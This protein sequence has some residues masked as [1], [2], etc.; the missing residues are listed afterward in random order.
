[1]GVLFRLSWKHKEITLYIQRITIF[2]WRIFE[3]CFFCF[4]WLPYIL[5]V[6]LCVTN[7]SFICSWAKIIPI[8]KRPERQEPCVGSEAEAKHI[9]HL[10]GSWKKITPATDVSAPL[11]TWVGQPSSSRAPG[12][13]LQP[14]EAG[15]RFTLRYVL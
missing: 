14:E 8:L 10:W 3:V 6:E 7:S 15:A 5:T 13:A 4:Q 1:M 12:A 11:P 9:P 2:F